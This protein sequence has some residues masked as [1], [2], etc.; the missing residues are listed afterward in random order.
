[1]EEKEWRGRGTLNQSSFKLGVSSEKIKTN[2]SGL[3]P[4]PRGPAG[5]E[6]AAKERKGIFIED[7]RPGTSKNGTGNKK[8][9]DEPV[10]GDS[11]QKRPNLLID[12]TKRRTH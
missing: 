9:G 3:K 2:G 12:F 6:Q 8:R 4:T 5:E 10:C 11:G 1:V 7:A